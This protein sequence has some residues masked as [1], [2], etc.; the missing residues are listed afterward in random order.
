[1]KPTAIEWIA[2]ESGV[3]RGVSAPLAPLLNVVLESAGRKR[4]A[5]GVVDSGS[6]TSCMPPHLAQALRLELEGP[7]REL[8]VLG[9]MATVRS[10]FCDLR[11]PLAHRVLTFRGVEFAVSTSAEGDGLVILGHTPLFNEVEIRFQ[12]WLRRFGIQRRIGNLTFVQAA[13]RPPPRPK[14]LPSRQT[15]S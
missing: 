10:A 4:A 7:P 2:Y 3:T 12:G 8:R 5:L 11:V 14:T 13:P 15:S 9:G 1:M 6:E